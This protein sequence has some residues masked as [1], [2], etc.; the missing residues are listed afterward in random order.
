VNT[1]HARLIA[2]IFA[3]GGTVTTGWPQGHGAS[4]VASSDIAVPAGWAPVGLIE[5]CP[6]VVMVRGD[7]PIASPADIAPWLRSGGLR[8][9]A[10]TATERAAAMS[11]AEAIA[12]PLRGVPA[13][14]GGVA[15]IVAGMADL[16]CVPAV[17]VK[18]ATA[19]NYVNAIIVAGEEPN[20]A[21]WDAVTAVDARVPL[22]SASSWSG[23]YASDRGHGWVGRLAAR[24]ADADVLA[25][26]AEAGHTAP[27]LTHR[28]PEAHAALLAS[29]RER[30]EAL[31]RSTG[32]TFT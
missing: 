25:T 19:N 1:P 15:A 10:G 32:M 5:M 30:Y 13:P 12:A 21:V 28:T 22:F 23:L 31:S 9:A 26:L 16:C 29:S 4:V 24:L 11:L 2:G 17:D 3:P 20:A 14:N 18:E 6:M 8:I 7:A 27:P